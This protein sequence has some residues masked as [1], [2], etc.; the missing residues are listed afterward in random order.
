LFQD[1]SDELSTLPGR[2]FAD[3]PV[4]SLLSETGTARRSLVCDFIEK[5]KEYQLLVEVPGLSKEDVKISLGRN[6]ML[7]VN[8][9]RKME[10]E[11]DIDGRHVIE[12]SYGRLSRSLQ[13]PENADIDKIKAHHEQGLLKVLIPKGEEAHD[14]ER[15]I[16]I[17]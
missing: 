3:L 1:L 16:A 11:E 2:V 14:S 8:A 13:L 17:E 12:R 5:D 15:T 9:E 10:H 7:H 4:P 6:R